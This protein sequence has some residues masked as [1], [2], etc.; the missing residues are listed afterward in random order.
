MT[1]KQERFVEEYLIDGNATQAARRAGYAHAKTQGPRML[2]NVGI[3]AAIAAAQASR[4]Q[5]VQVTQDYVL[6]RLMMEAEREGEGSSH[7]ARVSALEKLGK[8]MAMFTDKTEHSGG[9]TVNIGG[10]DAD[11]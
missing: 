1:P 7:A 3:V 10:K 5:R 2:E 11:L 8:T 6:Q 9:V 4:V